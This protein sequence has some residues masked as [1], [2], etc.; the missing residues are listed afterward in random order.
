MHSSGRMTQLFYKMGKRDIVPYRSEKLSGSSRLASGFVGGSLWAIAGQVVSAVG[1][2]L[3]VR[4]ITEYVSPSTF[5]TVSL[6]MGIV[7]LGSGVCGGPIFQALL[8]MYPDM[9]HKS[10]L[11]LLMMAIRRLLIESNGLLIAVAMAAGLIIVFFLEGSFVVLLILAGLVV[12]ETLRGL[13]ATTLSAKNE[14]KRYALVVAVDVLARQGFAV[15]L[16][17]ILGAS[18]TSIIG[19]YLVGAAL[20]SMWYVSVLQEINMGSD[21]CNESRQGKQVRQEIIEFSRPLM[22]IALAGSVSGLGDRYVIGGIL[23]VEAAGIYAAVYGLVSKPF[24]MISTALELALRQSYYHAVSTNDERGQHKVM[25]T[26]VLSA[27]VASVI[28][29]GIV[30]FSADELTRLLLGEKFK[31]GASLMPWIALGY[32]LFALSSPLERRA[33]AR[34]RTGSV[35]R[36]QAGG[37]AASVLAGMVGT[38]FYG[39]LGAA[40]A[41]P[42][43]FGCQLA[44]AACLTRK[45]SRFV[46][47]S[48]KDSAHK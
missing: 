42:V 25:S 18:V 37:A 40:W 19:G 34:K 24:L 1:M 29:L 22:P 33:Y 46:L 10:Q 7:A 41:V 48:E 12:V 15:L 9:Q 11:P 38:Y 45:S 17:L 32:C 4:I 39:I 36:I 27:L 43:Y 23:G 21:S 44:L 3:G 35:L 47:Y 2:V 31:S 20:L 5:G 6:L 14:I 30:T 26:W 16:V 8:R 13:V 28:C